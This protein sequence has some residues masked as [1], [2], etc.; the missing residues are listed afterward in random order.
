MHTYY[1]TEFMVQDDCKQPPRKVTPNKIEKHMK[2]MTISFA[3]KGRY[4]YVQYS[5]IV[6]R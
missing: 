6:A 5:N 1:E 2:I 3:K 4:T